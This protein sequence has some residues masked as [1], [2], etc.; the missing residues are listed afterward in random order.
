MI[1]ICS[2]IIDFGMHTDIT[3]GKSD[4]TNLDEV[5]AEID[6]QYHRFLELIGKKLDYFK[7]MQ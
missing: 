3:K 4:F 7:A 2:S 6:A 1:R 5:V